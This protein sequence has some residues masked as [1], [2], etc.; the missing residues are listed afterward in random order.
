MIKIFRRIRQRLLTE[1]KFS[2]YLL[3]AMGE[4]ILVVIGILIAL[5]INNANDASKLHKK[6]LTLLTEMSRNL[7]TD[8]A[9][10]EYNIDGNT[11]RITSDEIILKTLQERIPMHDSLKPHYGRLF[12]NYQ[13]SEN[14]A[15]WT[16][17]QS[18]GL[19][20]VSD[21]S[22][23]NAIS[24]LYTVKYEYLE[25]IEKGVDDKY[26]W[27]S[28]Y[29]QFLELIN[30]DEVWVSA[31]PVDHVALMDN[32]KFQ[33]TIKMNLFI[34]KFIQEQYLIIHQDIHSLLDKLERHM[35]TLNASK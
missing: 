18:V 25:N 2:R 8:L 29:P 24:Q 21:D 3:Y 35:H 33:E 30:W 23:R 11:Q 5:S 17:L 14:T 22:L 4:I 31:T 13:L 16:T 20:L 15:A 9:D 27:N 34:R 1:N 19:D 26:Q 32:R 6:E 28:I 12:G 10:L 7:Q